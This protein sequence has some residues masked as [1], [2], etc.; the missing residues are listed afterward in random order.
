MIASKGGT[1]DEIIDKEGFRKAVV[2]A[3]QGE[4]IKQNL[5]IDVGDFLAAFGDKDFALLLHGVQSKAS[6]QSAQSMANSALLKSMQ[7]D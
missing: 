1:K 3:D 5:H 6:G 4:A 7:N 2:V